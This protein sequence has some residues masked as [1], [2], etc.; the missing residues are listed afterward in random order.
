[1]MQQLGELQHEGN[2]CHYKHPLS[3]Q[4]AISLLQQLIRVTSSEGRRGCARRDES[5]FRVFSIENLVL[6]QKPGLKN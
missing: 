2:V 1:M 4:W 3:F 5:L 6:L